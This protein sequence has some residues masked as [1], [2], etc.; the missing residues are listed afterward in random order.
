MTIQEAFECMINNEKVLYNGSAFNISHIRSADFRIR[1]NGSN[2][3][4]VSETLI[5]KIKPKKRYWI[6]DIKSLEGP[7]YKSHY[8]SDDEGMQTS[9]KKWFSK[10]Q[11]IKKHENEFIDVDVEQ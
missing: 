8:Y 5:S 9:G 1:L 11:L 6:W 2:I 3:M 10:S 7:I 4:Y